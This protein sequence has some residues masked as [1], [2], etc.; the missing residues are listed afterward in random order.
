MARNCLED[1]SAE[2]EG[3]LSKDGLEWCVGVYVFRGGGVLFYV[4]RKR[5]WKGAMWGKK[6]M[7]FCKFY[8]RNQGRGRKKKS[9]GHME[10]MWRKKTTTA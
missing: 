5:S 1:V 3:L 10:K 6:K 7:Y 4:Y 9:N 8:H 2:A